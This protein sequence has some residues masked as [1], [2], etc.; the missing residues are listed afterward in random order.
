MEQVRAMKLIRIQVGIAFIE[1]LLV[2][3][4]VMIVMTI[5]AP[6][7]ISVLSGN[8]LSRAGQSVS[9]QFSL[10]RQEAVSKS[11]DVVVVFSPDPERPGEG[12]RGLQLWR[13]DNSGTNFV[14]IGPRILLPPKA[15]FSFATNQSPLL[16][17][18][19]SLNGS[20]TNG[21]RFRSNGAAEAIGGLSLNNNFLTIVNETTVTTNTVATNFFTIQ[22]NPVN[23]KV[24]IYRP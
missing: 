7:L 8:D 6:S 2:L 11:R 4:I 17:R 19:V 14:R 18:T 24:A 20:N 1:I 13:A 15:K 3:A 23:G 21:F 16:F 9:D 5:S 22:V 10:G 12:I